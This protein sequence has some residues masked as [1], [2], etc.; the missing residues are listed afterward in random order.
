MKYKKIFPLGYQVLI[1][2]VDEESRVSDNGIV[3]PDSTEEEKKSFGEV[4]KIGDKVKKVKVGEHVMYG[5]YSG[6]RF[7]LNKEELIV[8]HQQFIL[9]RLE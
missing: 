8:V 4:L 3:T 7:E 2:P 6:D 1:K 5:T 9:A